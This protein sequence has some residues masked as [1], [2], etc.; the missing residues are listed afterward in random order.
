MSMATIIPSTAERGPTTEL[1]AERD[2][3]VAEL[4][5]SLT[6]R[7]LSVASEIHPLVKTGGLADV[8]GA[9]PAALERE[10]VAVRTLVPGYPA[11]L[12]ALAGAAVAAEIPDLFGG[13]ARL[14]AGTAAGLDLVAIDAPHLYGRPGTPYL[15]PDGTDW[16]DNAA[17]FGALGLVAARIG[18]GLL[19][20]YRPDVVHG[21]DWQA[22]L[23][24]AYLHFAQ[25]PKPRTVATVHSLAFAGQFPAWTLSA[26]GLPEEAY[27]TEGLEYHGTLSFLKAALFYADHVTAVSPGYADEIMTHEGGM[28][29]DGLLRARAATVTGVRLGIDDAIW[30]PSND[31]DI[32]APYAVGDMGGRAVDK[33]ALQERFGLD[34]APDALLFGV[35]SRLSGQKG[36][37]LVLDALP[38]IAELGGQLVVV[39]EGDRW[40]EDSFRAAAE[41]YPGRVG[42]VIGVDERLAHLVQAGADAVLVPSRFEPC[43]LVQ[44]CALRY[45]AVPVVSRVGGLADTVVDANEMALAAGAATGVVFA[46]VTLPALEAALRRTAAIFRDPE[47]WAGMVVAGMATDVSWRRPARKLAALYRDLLTSDAGAHP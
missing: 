20:D 44:L 32:P 39:G 15:A 36:L 30:D 17:R 4:T 7:V 28:G 29:F 46:P 10:G 38:L 43:G 23:A 24:P 1:D 16:P 12:E 21:H 14:L 3:G 2:D 5:R 9:L 6:I 8:V 35:V 13:P 31:P 42:A 47:D 37:D 27:R 19:Q 41:R 18:T 40:F 34:P 25:H 11:V 22:G 26:L 33:A 45:G